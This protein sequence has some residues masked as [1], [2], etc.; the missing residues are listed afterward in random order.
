MCSVYE[1]EGHAHVAEYAYAYWGRMQTHYK[2]NKHSGSRKSPVFRWKVAPVP[3]RLKKKS[4]SSR[5]LD[6]CMLQILL[7]L[8]CG[9]T[10]LAHAT[11]SCSYTYLLS[12]LIC[13]PYRTLIR[14]LCHQC[15]LWVCEAGESAWACCHI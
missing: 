3:I 2:D 9:K 14:V 13:T 4:S 1:R 12:L 5:E 15:A 11:H 6:F 10:A 7:W 8:E